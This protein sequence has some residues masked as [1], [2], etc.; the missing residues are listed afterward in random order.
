[1]IGVAARA[2]GM[3][4]EPR[5]GW[6]LVARERAGHAAAFAYVAILALVPA[7]ARLFG[8][9]LIGGHIPLS[10]GLAAA[11]LAYGLGIA[12]VYGVAIA[13][14]VLAPAFGGVRNFSNAARLSAYSFTPVF[15]AGI[16]LLVPGAS[17]L[18][19]LGLYGAI[20]LCLGL[21][22]LMRTPRGKTLACVAA[23]VGCALALEIAA[24]LAV[25]ALAWR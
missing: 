3:L 4:L 10:T 23:V 24:A 7:L 8:G 17:F 9:T 15:V 11:L 18:S 5:T 16:F 19:L 1:M 6:S 25:A 21:P 20:L 13:I 2:K 14:D 22:V 12:K